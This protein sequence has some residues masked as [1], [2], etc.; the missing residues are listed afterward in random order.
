MPGSSASQTVH[1]EA[2][3]LMSTGLPR[4]LLCESRDP[5]SVAA[6][7]SGAGW[8]CAS[9]PPERWRG[10]GWPGSRPR[11]ESAEHDRA[12][13]QAAHLRHLLEQEVAAEAPRRGP[14]ASRGFVL[15]LPGRDDTS[16]AIACD[17]SPNVAEGRSSKIEVARGRPGI[18]RR[19]VELRPPGVFMSTTST[20]GWPRRSASATRRSRRPKPFDYT[21]SQETVSRIRANPMSS[22]R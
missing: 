20:S 22:R 1:Q 7:K 6:L 4:S 12:G 10:A 17:S 18:A 2:K 15:E 19:Q 5:W 14:A 16:G 8:S 11:A 21:A 9:L 13:I 3:K